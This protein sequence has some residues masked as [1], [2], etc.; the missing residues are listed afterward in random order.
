LAKRANPLLELMSDVRSV[1]LVEPALTDNTNQLV[2]A[3]TALHGWG[4][5][6]VVPG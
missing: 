3:V 4:D 6:E 5:Q 2:G 1:A